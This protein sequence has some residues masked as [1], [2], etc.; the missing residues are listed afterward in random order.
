MSPVFYTRHHLFLGCFVAPELIRD[1]RTWDVLTA[2]EQLAEEL[3]RG[4]LVP[5]AL[6]QDIKHVPVLIDGSPEVGRLPVDLEKD[7]IQVPFVSRPSASSPELIGV[8]LTEFSR[9]LP[10]GFVAHN[11]TTFGQEFF[12][13]TK[14]QAETKVKPYRVRDDLLGKPKTIVR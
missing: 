4:S 14:T 8:G 11:D 10:H 9:P 1:H 6:H 5:S 2:L 3:L 7:F 13:I 12:D